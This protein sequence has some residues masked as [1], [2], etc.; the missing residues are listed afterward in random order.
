MTKAIVT[1]Q[2]YSANIATQNQDIFNE[3]NSQQLQPETLENVNDVSTFIV[4][5]LVIALQ[6][7]A[8]GEWL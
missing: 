2:H 6:L 7:E 5:N 8:G 1:T 3:D 4:T